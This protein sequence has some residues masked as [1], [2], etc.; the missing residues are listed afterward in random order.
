M[1]VVDA[2]L[3]VAWLLN[4]PR[5]SA[6]QDVWDML[7]EESVLVPAHWPN[8]VANALRR[9][10][11]RKRITAAEIGPSLNEL[12]PFDIKLAT[13]PAL[14][15]IESITREAISLD[16]SV[17]DLQ[18]VNLARDHRAPIATIDAAMRAAARKIN[19]LVLPTDR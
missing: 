18:Y 13:A 19:L 11:R 17:Y 14:Q 12:A 10:V 5:P 15:D 8:E 16:L 9:A 7:V 3:F 6:E 2:S 4:E 1:I